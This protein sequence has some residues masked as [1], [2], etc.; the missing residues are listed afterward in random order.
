MA[1]GKARPAGQPRA[2]VSG[3]RSGATNTREPNS[4]LVLLKTPGSMFRRLAIMRACL[5]FSNSSRCAASADNQTVSFT[6]VVSVVGA[7]GFQGFGRF[8][9]I[10]NDPGFFHGEFGAFNKV[11]KI[12]FPERTVLRFTRRRL[13]QLHEALRCQARLERPEKR[14]PFGI[15]GLALGPGTHEVGAEPAGGNFAFNRGH[16]LV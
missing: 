13:R 15:I 11:G 16:Q 3:T 1:E 10:N 4:L 12:R 8:R 7:L 5:R 9:V 14:H 6:D 2:K